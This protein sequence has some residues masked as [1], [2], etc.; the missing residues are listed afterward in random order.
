ML[1]GRCDIFLVLW[2]STLGNL[3]INAKLGD[4]VGLISFID[5]FKMSIDP[6]AKALGFGGGVRVMP[7]K[8]AA[9]L[10]CLQ[11]AL[12]NASSD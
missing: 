7:V 5:R 8:G 11:T 6:F 12:G 10:L 1:L 3:I 9:D 2:M 4:K